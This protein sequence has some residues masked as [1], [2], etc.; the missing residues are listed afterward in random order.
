MVV[1]GIHPPV[2]D[3]DLI[4]SI[5]L[6]A[7]NLEDFAGLEFAGDV[8]GHRHHRT[9][10]TLAKRIYRIAQLPDQA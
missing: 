6:T 1:G 9:Q 10:I 4:Q 3:R 5:N 7:M 2:V 8:G